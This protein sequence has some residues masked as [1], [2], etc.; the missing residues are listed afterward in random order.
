[1]KVFD[2]IRKI[3]L[4]V[5]GISATAVS[6]S[7]T[8]KPLMPSDLKQQTIVT[9]P[10]TLRKGFLR[11]GSML[12]YR[13]A[14]K[15]FSDDGE[16]QYYLSNSWGTRT[17]FNFSLQY[18]LS[19]RFEIEFRGEYMD[20]R[21]ESEKTEYIA[22][23]NTSRS[24]VTK[25]KGSGIGDT[26][27]R[28]RYQ[29]L[30]ENRY[31]VSLTGTLQ[32]AIPTGEKNPTD[33][34]SAERYDLP[35]GQ[36]NYALSCGFSGRTVLYPYSFTASLNYVWNFEG[37]K[38]FSASDASEVTFRMG[39]VIEASAGVNLH[40]NDWIV[41]SNEMLYNRKDKGTINGNTSSLLPESWSLSYEPG[42][43]FQ[44]KRFRLGESV[45][46]P[47]KGISIPADPL[48]MMLIQYIF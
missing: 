40:L 41:F 18:G 15:Y 9:E 12:N 27:L 36:G 43:V 20:T 23:T 39:N 30:P 44:V 11:V 46:I 17:S 24:V 22:S 16:K 8:E 47:L 5:S 19:D 26:Y 34:Y 13:V 45:N 37:S 2:I 31:L 25:Q 1:M 32:A 48:Y 38:K 28:L 29:L 4:S 10:V 14:D 3:I 35:V 42:L 6:F 21:Q 33:I 7:Q